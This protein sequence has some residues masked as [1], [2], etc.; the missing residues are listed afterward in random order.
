MLIV[1][2]DD[3]AMDANYIPDAGGEVGTSSR[4]CGDGR[5]AGLP[6]GRASALTNVAMVV[7]LNFPL[8]PNLW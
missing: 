4:V 5:Q 6:R 2:E 1:P 3:D 7:R 8:E